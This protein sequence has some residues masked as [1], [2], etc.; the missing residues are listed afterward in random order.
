MYT[1][2]CQHF[3]IFLALHVESITIL[4]TC[5]S[6]MYT[7]SVISPYNFPSNVHFCCI[8]INLGVQI[9]EGVDENFVIWWNI[10]IHVH[11]KITFKT[12][13]VTRILRSLTLILWLRQICMF[14]SFGQNLEGQ[15]VMLQELHKITRHYWCSYYQFFVKKIL[16]T[17]IFFLKIANTLCTRVRRIGSRLVRSFN[18][19]SN[20]AWP[21]P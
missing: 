20:E 9:W 15:N 16:R 14:Y 7:F 11:L 10:Y 2:N 5:I 6:E 3:E 8:S 21:S 1:Y 12:N 17:R 18:S 4:N 19:D 13:C